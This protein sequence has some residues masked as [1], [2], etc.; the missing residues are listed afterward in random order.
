LALVL[1]ASAPA[2]TAAGP[3]AKSPPA[4]LPSLLRFHHGDALPELV[5]IRADGTEWRLSGQKG[6][7]TIVGMVTFDLALATPPI[8]QQL[9]QVAARSADYGVETVAVVNWAKPDDFKAWAGQHAAAFSFPV[10]GDPVGPFAGEPEDQEGRL[11]HHRRTVL[12]GM[13]GGGMTPPLPAFF[14]VDGEQR[15]VGSFRL[16]KAPAD[17][18]FVGVGNLLLRAG[19]PLAGAD[20]PATVPPAEFWVKAA[21]RPKEAPVTPVAVGAVA[22]DFL[23]HDVDGKPVRLADHAGKVVVLDF[24]ATWCGPCK[25]AL[26]HVQELAQHYRAQGAVV[27]ASCTNDGRDEF[28][29][30]VR[31]HGSKYPDV[32]FAHDPLERAESRASRQHYGVGGI[33]HQFVIGRDG[34]IASQVIGY[35]QG[36]VLL[37]AAL[38]KAGLIVDPAVLEQAATNERRREEMDRKPR[39]G[40][41]SIGK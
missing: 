21:P 38:A 25:T 30:W 10:V 4:F 35:M 12:G 23:M 19:V 3:A 17:D 40:S 11:Q 22:K 2:Q 33:P 32:I 8:L 37:D 34:K 20:R 28:V 41:K 27:I 1:V 26:P 36:E 13:F 6:K 16:P 14:V 24:W 29:A 18:A 15:L 31:E 9:A 39:P 5:A 7:C